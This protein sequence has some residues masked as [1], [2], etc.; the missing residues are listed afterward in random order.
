MPPIIQVS[1]LV[2]RPPE[3]VFD[4]LMEQQVWRWQGNQPAAPAQDS[5]ISALHCWALA[6]N[7]RPQ[8]L[9][10]SADLRNGGQL[11]LIHRI[12]PQ[13]GGT[14]LEREITYTGPAPFRNI[15]LGM[16]ASARFQSEFHTLT[17]RIKTTLEASAENSLN[18]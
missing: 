12:T 2:S 18:A 10:A 6:Q 16:V 15:L 4:F 5:G 7:K 1:T 8:L 9:V 3:Q 17:Q 14:V 13:P 11:S